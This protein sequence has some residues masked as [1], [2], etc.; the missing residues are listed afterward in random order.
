VDALVAGHVTPRTTFCPHD[1]DSLG[2]DFT[3]AA[4]GSCGDDELIVGGTDVRPGA[5]VLTT[6]NN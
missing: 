3:A 6:S 1:W 4:S 5:S 2:S